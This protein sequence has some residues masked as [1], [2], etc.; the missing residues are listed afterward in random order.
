MMEPI[1]DPPM[2][3]VALLD[4]QPVKPMQIPESIEGKAV[5]LHEGNLVSYELCGVSCDTYNVLKAHLSGK[6]R[7]KNVEKLEKALGPDTAPATEPGMLENEAK[8]RAELS[9]WM[10]ITGR[11]REW[12]AMRI[13]REKRQ[14][15]LHGTA[16]DALRTYRERRLSK[17][18]FF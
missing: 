18:F 17:I 11:Q 10:E 14:N 7:Q 13:W 9:L 4:T 6:K 15:I 2:T 5:N 8:N 3:L 16:M 1:P 12:D